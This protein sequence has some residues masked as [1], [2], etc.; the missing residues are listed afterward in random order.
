MF[1]LN[2]MKLERKE[3]AVS[4]QFPELT[5]LPR[6]AEITGSES[7]SVKDFQRLSM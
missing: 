7:Q 5:V 2:Y 6:V 1:Y 3:K 4:L